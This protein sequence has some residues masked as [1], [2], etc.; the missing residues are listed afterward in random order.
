[1]VR[2]SGREARQ[3][4][5]PFIRFGPAHVPTPWHAARGELLDEQG[6]VVDEAL[7]TWFAAPRSYTAED[8]VEVSC[9]GSP[10]ILRHVVAMALKHGARAA[11]PGEFTLRAFMNGR[12]DLPQAEAV[13]DLIRATTLYQAR[14]AARQLGG[15][16]S[17]GV[18]PIK[19]QVVEL[20]ALLEAGIDFAED[21]VSVAPAEEILRRLKL[22]AT[23]LERLARSYDYGRYVHDGFSL[24]IAGRPNVGKSSLF[25]ALLGRERA[26]VTA[27]PGTTRDTISESLSLEG[28]PV[29]LVDTAGVRESAD[30]VES[31]GIER[32]WQAMAD[33]DITIIVID[34][35]RDFTPEDRRLLERASTQGRCLTVVN[36]ADLPQAAEVE[37]AIRVSALTGE[38]IGALRGQVVEA[39]GRGSAIP[40]EDA[41]ITSARQGRLLSES[42]EAI[43]NAERAVGFGLPHEMLL[44]DAYAALRPLDALTGATTADDILN[45]IF[46]T[47]CIGK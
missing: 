12:I 38:G 8:V 28:I 17:K 4:I 16:I 45:R 19:D 35:S 5:E 20:I 11:E 24:A 18:E 13:N 26:I 43:Q 23:A 44:L 3:V 25:N 36:K 9:H 30:L 47:F 39:L 29:R 21:D 22:I 15:S 31:L 34:G 2:I 40:P 6:A 37:G 42:L 14:V 33:A 27:V 1:M 32:T 41:V 10:V 46:S 7:V